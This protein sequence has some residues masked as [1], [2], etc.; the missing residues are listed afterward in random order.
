MMTQSTFV[1]SKRFPYLIPDKRK[2]EAIVAQLKIKGVTT[3]H[4]KKS[5]VD[6][7]VNI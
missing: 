7:F 1:R 4:T 5:P 2:R 6:P 3:R